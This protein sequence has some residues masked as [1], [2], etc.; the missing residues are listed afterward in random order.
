MKQ[1]FV[2]SLFTTVIT[3]Y[4]ADVDPANSFVQAT[5]Q[6]PKFDKILLGN[7]FVYG[8]E[9]DVTT[10]ATFPTAYRELAQSYDFHKPKHALRFFP[11]FIAHYCKQHKEEHNGRE[12][13]VSTSDVLFECKQQYPI[14]YFAYMARNLCN[15]L[16]VSPQTTENITRACL[17]VVAGHAIDLTDERLAAYDK[18]RESSNK[19]ALIAHIPNP[20]KEIILSD[21]DHDNR[22]KQETK[23]LIGTVF[24]SVNGKKFSLDHH[25][26]GHIY[27]LDHT[28]RA[29][30]TK[31]NAATNSCKNLSYV[32]PQTT[33][34]IAKNMRTLIIDKKSVTGQPY[35]Q[36]VELRNFKDL[37][38]ILPQTLKTSAGYMTSTPYLILAFEGYAFNNPNYQNALVDRSHFRHWSDG[39]RE[40]IAQIL[41]DQGFKNVNFGDLLQDMIQLFVYKFEESKKTN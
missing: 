19:L 1:L 33:V 36:T 40:P 30:I 24:S 39:I 3:S 29:I 27:T 17:R 12:W 2:Y 32:S 37:K 15:F 20:L 4:G 22:C 23:E 13:M 21:Y 38:F 34:A 35:D 8:N 9:F 31:H 11:P 16:D 14:C 26:S 25:I 6:F 28:V 41:Q 18:A 10:I 5:K 7:D